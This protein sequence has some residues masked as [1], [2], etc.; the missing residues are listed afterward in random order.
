MATWQLSM[1]PN[2]FDFIDGFLTRH[3]LPNTIK[4]PKGSANMKKCQL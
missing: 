1:G 3:E 2:D 4:Y